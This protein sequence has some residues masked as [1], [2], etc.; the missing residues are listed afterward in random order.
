M[1]GLEGGNIVPTLKDGCQTL[2]RLGAPL[3]QD[4]GMDTVF[5]ADLRKRLFLFQ[6]IQC[7]LGFEGSSVNLFHPETY[8]SSALSSV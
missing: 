6:Q 1:C 8:L 5:G 3:A 4:I 7:D 2:Q